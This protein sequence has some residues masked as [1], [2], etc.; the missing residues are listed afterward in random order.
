VLVLLIMIV[1]SSANMVFIA[2][3]YE[4][5]NQHSTKYFDDEILDEVF[6]AD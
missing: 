1:T 3:V 6:V 2:A 5:V 4:H